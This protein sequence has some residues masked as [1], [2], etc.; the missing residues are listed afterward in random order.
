[1]H[2]TVVAYFIQKYS[3]KRAEHEFAAA[4][5]TLGARRVF[6]NEYRNFA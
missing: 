3:Q 6:F 2:A 1:M 5:S 4:H